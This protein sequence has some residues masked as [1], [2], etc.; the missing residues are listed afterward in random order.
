MY[1]EQVV[2][3][4]QLM[5]ILYVQGE[6][7]L[8]LTLTLRGSPVP[9]F[10]VLVIVKKNVVC[11]VIKQIS[12]QLGIVSGCQCP[13]K[14]EIQV[15]MS[16]RTSAEPCLSWLPLLSLVIGHSTARAPDSPSHL[17]LSVFP[18]ICKS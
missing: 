12:S 3:H 11:P 4:M 14:Q 17:N 18:K 6:S 7:N 13:S 9:L 10:I 2:F 16:S 8:T 15:R 5:Y 1:E